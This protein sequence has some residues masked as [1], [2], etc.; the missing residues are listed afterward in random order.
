MIRFMAQPK[1]LLPD[2]NKNARL[3]SSFVAYCEKH[4]EQRFWQAL[5]NWSGF[6]F[7]GAATGSIGNNFKDLY[8]VNGVCGDEDGQRLL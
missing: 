8:Y 5:N 3:L 2:K 4:P 7:I 6:P 1:T